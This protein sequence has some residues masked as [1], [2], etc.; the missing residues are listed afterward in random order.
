VVK[1]ALRFAFSRLYHERAGNGEEFS[2][3]RVYCASKDLRY[4]KGNE[5]H[6]S[7]IGDYFVNIFLT[8]AASFANGILTNVILILFV[9]FLCL[10]LFDDTSS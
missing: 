6:R 8:E 7:G 4:P 9:C 10:F 2:P 5:A 1:F 3:E